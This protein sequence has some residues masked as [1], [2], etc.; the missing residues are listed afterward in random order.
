MNELRMYVERLFE[1]RVLTAENI[2]L[3]EEIYGNL[4]ARYED[5][6]ADGMDEADALAKTMAS[7]TSIEDVLESGANATQA[8]LPAADAD[9]KAEKPEAATLDAGIGVEASHDGDAAAENVTETQPMPTVNES[10][11]QKD[12]T[13]QVQDQSTPT[14]KESAMIAGMPRKKFF[15]IVGVV[16]AILLAC[17]GAIYA[18]SYMGG[19]DS[20]VDA[21]ATQREQTAQGSASSASDNTAAQDTGQDTSANTTDT[22]STSGSASNTSSSTIQQYLD[23]ED[24]RE[25][26]ATLALL[27]E[28]DESAV[29]TLQNAAS[30]SSTVTQL[31]KALPMGSSI[32]SVSTGSNGTALSVSYTNVSEDCDDDA[33]EAVLVYNATAAFAVYPDV[34]TVKISV[35]EQHDSAHDADHYVFMRT[36]LENGIASASSNAITQLNNTLFDSSDSWNQVRTYVT[37]HRFADHQIDLADIYD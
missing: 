18:I 21:V 25:Y 16:V 6:I 4:I 10:E 13:S 17:T 31:F 36:N 30:G 7:I 32:N 12:E 34:D 23:P 11:D 20:G 35:Q 8:P 2:E 1:G 37:A 9:D 24:Q 5:Y 29:S 3:K 19:Q 27:T 15:T 14:S 28:L 33:V 26:E 22:S